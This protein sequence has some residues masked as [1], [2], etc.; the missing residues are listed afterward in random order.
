M[1][2][3]MATEESTTQLPVLD[4]QGSAGRIAENRKRW[5]RAFQYYVDGKGIKS[6]E[7]QRSLLLHHAGMQVQDIFEDLTDPRADSPPDGDTQR[8]SRHPFVWAV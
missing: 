8:F 2:D 3:V 5:I 6:P 4:L 7:R 1:T